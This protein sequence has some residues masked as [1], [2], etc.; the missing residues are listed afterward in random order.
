MRNNVPALLCGSIR[1][2]RRN[3]WLLLFVAGVFLASCSATSPTPLD[4]AADE[5]AGAEEPEETVKP[6]PPLDPVPDFVLR[7]NLAPDGTILPD[8]MRE[9]AE[10]HVAD[11]YGTT[12]VRVE[13]GVLYLDKG[14]DMTGVTWRGPLVRKDFEIT[15]EAMRVEGSD[16]FCGLTFPVGPDPCTLVLGGWGGSLTGLSSVDYEDAANNITARMI[17]YENGRWYKVRL[18]VYGDK[19]EAWLDD[20]QIVELV[21]KGRKIGIRWEV[22]ASVPLGIATWRT[23]GAIRNMQFKA[24][25]SVP[26]DYIAPR[27]ESR[28]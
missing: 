1:M 19:I 13:D 6:R 20:R 24:L 28:W 12:T 5:T 7:H 18:R 27:E 2:F 10:W 14:N 11:F 21:F 3:P 22:E 15:L 8:T 4:L 9:S 16:F 26:F 17:D 23:T 25:T